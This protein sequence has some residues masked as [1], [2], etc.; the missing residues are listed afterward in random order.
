[1]YSYHSPMRSITASQDPMIEHISHTQKSVCVC[2]VSRKL[3]QLQIIR[4]ANQETARAWEFGLL[5]SLLAPFL[6]FILMYPTGQNLL[7]GGNPKT[8]PLPFSRPG[9]LVLLS[10]LSNRS[11][12]SFF[13][14]FIF[15]DFFLIFVPILVSRKIDGLFLGLENLKKGTLS[16][17]CEKRIFGLL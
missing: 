4:E 11:T 8:R 5:L 6:H 9:I 16:F 10:P 15:V 7:R 2:T 1:M 13:F 14:S 17:F 12:I 3:L